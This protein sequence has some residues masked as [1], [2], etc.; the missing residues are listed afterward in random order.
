MDVLLICETCQARLHTSRPEEARRRSCPRCRERRLTPHCAGVLDRNAQTTTPSGSE[1]RPRGRSDVRWL[2]AAAGSLCAALVTLVLV[3]R[4]AWPSPT[5]ESYSVL[6]I[7]LQPPTDEAE[8]T[9]VHMDGSLAIQKPRPDEGLWP[10]GE[11]PATPILEEN[12]QAPRPPRPRP[13]TSAAESLGGPRVAHPGPNSAP[14]SPAPSTVAPVRPAPP[15]APRRPPAEDQHVKVRDKNDGV[16][17]ARVYGGPNSDVALMPDGRLEWFRGKVRT[18]EPFRADTLAE[19]ERKLGAGPYQGF[20]ATKTE[21][22]LVFSKGSKKFT[23]QSAHLLESLYRGLL[24]S[25]AEKGFE[26]HESEFPLVAV[27]YR[28]EADFRASNKEIDPDVQA[29]YD[30]FSNRIF[31][32]ETSNEELDAPDVAALRKPQTVAH[33][34]THQVLQNIGLH[35]R[36]A[37]WPPW[38][39]EGMA[40][41]CAPTTTNKRAE[42][43]G[44]SVINPFH[45]ATY[46]DLRNHTVHVI[47]NQGGA[48]QLKLGKRWIEDLV[49]RPRL[50]PV[51]YALS[52]ALTHYL[53]NKRTSAFIAYLKSMSQIPPLEKLTPD[54]HLRMFRKAFGSDAVAM[55]NALHTHLDRQ[56]FVPIPYYAVG[57]IQVMPSGII[58]RASI[59]SPSPSMIR[60]WIENITD[61]NGGAIRWEAHPFPSR[62]LAQD[63]AHLW[64]NNGQ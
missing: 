11:I 59:V 8:P 13:T 3:A 14:R 7:I 53:A 2:A 54:D 55:G 31:F 4:A 24:A 30:I 49:S 27:I 48:S 46:N 45:M 38:L 64:M 29:Y 19:L 10:D 32:Y 20:A 17:V 51:E 34:G 35:P 44:Y 41:F 25:L 37:K 61:P 5:I 22:Y 21:H 56:R 23:E 9:V 28:T 18:D 57:F 33:E 15:P 36:L 26:V 63:A 42:W 50:T 39:I 12:V 16:V 1:L 62:Q 43:A 40:E 52:W 58:R 60:Q 47:G 6:P